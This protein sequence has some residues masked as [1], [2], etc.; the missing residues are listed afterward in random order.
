MI[1]AD[2]VIDAGYVPENLRSALPTADDVARG[3]SLRPL[4]ADAT[5]LWDTA[6]STFTTGG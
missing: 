3:L 4:D 1:D 2:Y 6:W 5:A